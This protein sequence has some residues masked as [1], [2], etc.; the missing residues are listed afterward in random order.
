MA[1]S[2][3]ERDG[4]I[5]ADDEGRKLKTLL[6]ALAIAIELKH[7]RTRLEDVSAP[8]DEADGDPFG[9]ITDAPILAEIVVEGD[10]CAVGRFEDRR[11]SEHRGSA[12][13]QMRFSVTLEIDARFTVTLFDEG[14]R[15][16]VSRFEFRERAYTWRPGL[17]RIT[18]DRGKQLRERLFAYWASILRE[19]EG[20]DAL[21]IVFPSDDL[22]NGRLASRLKARCAEVSVFTLFED[23]HRRQGSTFILYREQESTKPQTTTFLTCQ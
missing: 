19:V 10:I 21:T 13:H 5:R 11:R 18:R 20:K 9:D 22:E 16:S 12:L 3:K 6:D 17:A 23:R 8:I 15:S 1:S 4:A 14:A 2:T 7:G